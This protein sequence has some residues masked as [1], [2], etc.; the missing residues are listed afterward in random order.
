MFKNIFAAITLLCI[1]YSCNHNN[2]TTT[3]TSLDTGREFIR[4]SLNGD[5]TSAEKL[6]LQ[7]TQN[8]QLFDSYK[9]YYDRLPADK[10]EHYRQANYD[11]NKYVDVDSTTTII[12]YSNDYMKKPMDIK[13]VRD[14]KQWK[15]DFKYTYAG[16]TPIN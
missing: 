15:I 8:L 7:D 14:N 6:L 4:A 12:T 9:A 13:V 16:N 10:K 2:S 11:I 1:L 3:T 5:F